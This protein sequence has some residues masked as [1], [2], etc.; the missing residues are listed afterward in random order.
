VDSQ[1]LSLYFVVKLVEAGLCL[2]LDMYCLL[3]VRAM[4]EG[5][6]ILSHIDI[7]MDEGLIHESVAFVFGC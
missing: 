2:V 3:H 1:T 7:I 4:V 5:P 6:C